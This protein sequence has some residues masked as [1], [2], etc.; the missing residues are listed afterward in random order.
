MS[1]E[2]RLGLPREAEPRPARSRRREPGPAV[3][4]RGR[5]APFLSGKGGARP[6]PTS[7]MQRHGASR[8]TGLERSGEA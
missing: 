1:A 7:A 3:Q 2:E 5:W 8:R 6:D 4:G